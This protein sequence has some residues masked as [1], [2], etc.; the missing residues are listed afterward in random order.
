[1]K[2]W[3]ID[4]FEPPPATYADSLAEVMKE[5]PPAPVAVGMR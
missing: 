4:A 3:Q 5:H 2:M 1:M